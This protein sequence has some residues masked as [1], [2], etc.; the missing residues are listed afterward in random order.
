[1]GHSHYPCPSNEL[2][3]T[4]YDVTHEV[5]EKPWGGEWGP[6]KDQ[7]IR[8]VDGESRPWYHLWEENENAIRANVE[9][10]FLREFVTSSS[11]SGINTG[12]DIPSTCTIPDC[13]GD[14][15]G[16]G[17]ICNHKE[18]KWKK[19]ISLSGV[20]SITATVT[21]GTKSVQQPADAGIAAF[22]DHPEFVRCIRPHNRAAIFKVLLKIHKTRSCRNAKYKSVISLY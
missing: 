22:V 12:E 3:F 11:F 6:P 8:T 20:S 2:K 18:P 19:I 9:P 15:Y 21:V 4:V 7:G 10:L 13:N 17:Y 16:D 1:M 14:S 5:L